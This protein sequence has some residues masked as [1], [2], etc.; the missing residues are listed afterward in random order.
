MS[1][2][3]ALGEQSDSPLGNGLEFKKAARLQSLLHLHPNWPCFEKLLNEGSNHPLKEIGCSYTKL[4]K[5]LCPMY[6]MKHKQN[7]P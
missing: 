2:K 3:K 4:P 6:V 7:I 1:I 5:F